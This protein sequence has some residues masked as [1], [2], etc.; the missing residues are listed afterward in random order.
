MKK[1][2]LTILFFASISTQLLSQKIYFNITKIDT[3]TTETFFS[4]IQS[5][6]K[7]KDLGQFS[8]TLFDSN[9]QIFQIT[10]YE[11]FIPKNSPNDFWAIIDKYEYKSG[12]IEK[13]EHWKTDNKSKMCKCSSWQFKRKGILLAVFWHP[14]CSKIAL[15]C[16]KF[17]NQLKKE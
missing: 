15:D 4:K 10:K 9:N 8:D 3:T 11:N 2:T 14:K 13:I 5:E 12:L 17:G 1:I 6:I 16:D 7:F